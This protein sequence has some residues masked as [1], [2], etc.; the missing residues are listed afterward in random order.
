MLQNDELG[1][2]LE[3]RAGKPLKQRNAAQELNH[4]KMQM[5]QTNEHREASS[6]IKQR[7]EIRV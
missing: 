1:D 6:E 3:R 5:K 7:I 2:F 4:C